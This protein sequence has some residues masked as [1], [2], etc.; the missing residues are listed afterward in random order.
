MGMSRGRVITNKGCGNRE[1]QA[2]CACYSTEL[3]A[4]V[5]NGGTDESVFSLVYLH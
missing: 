4:F 5:S 3:P 2:L 1:R